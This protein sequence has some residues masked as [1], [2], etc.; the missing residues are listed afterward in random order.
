MWYRFEKGNP[1]GIPRIKNYQLAWYDM[2]RGGSCFDESFFKPNEI[3][4]VITYVETIEDEGNN[5]R[6]RVFVHFD[7]GDEYELKLK[8]M[9]K[10]RKRDKFHDEYEDDFNPYE[11]ENLKFIWGVTSWDD[12]TGADAN[13][14][15]M[16]DIHIIYDKN[17][18]MYMLNVETAYIFETYGSE[19]Q[20]LQDCLKAFT[21]YMDDNGLNK[22]EPYR[23][24]MSNLCTNMEAETIEELYTNFKIFVDGFCKQRI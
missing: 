17:T 2:T 23:L 10:N 22:N 7:N 3:E 14:Y 6:C 1:V 9:Y 21:K 20:Y 13:L 24:L 4:N 12:L 5:D 18:K 15:T 16:N 11:D 19:C 8:K